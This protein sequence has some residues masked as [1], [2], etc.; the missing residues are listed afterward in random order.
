MEDDD[1]VAE[2][3]ATA[4][5][6]T[7]P[8][9]VERSVRQRVTQFAGVADP[10]V[11]AQAAGAGQRAA[12]EV[13]PELRRLLAADVDQQW[14]NPLSLLRRAVRYPTAVLRGAGVP[15]IVR[16]AYDERHFPDD[17]YGLTPLAFAD[18]DPSL[19]DVGLAWGAAKAMAHLARHRRPGKRGEP[20]AGEAS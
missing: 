16:H 15:P 13:G 20:G 10:E 2:R 11:M 1:D 3:L 5:E 18:V 9:W 8:G 4:V 19:H 14:T 6:A 12:A 7:L 17:E